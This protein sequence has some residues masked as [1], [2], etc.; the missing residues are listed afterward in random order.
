MARDAAAALCTGA[1]NRYPRFGSVSMKRG[2]SAVSPRAS[3]RRF[4]ALFSPRSKSTKVSAGHTCRCSSSRVTTSPA[5]SSRRI[6][7][8]N[9]WAAS[10]TRTPPFR[11]SPERRSIPKTPKEVMQSESVA[12]L[13]AADSYRPRS[14]ASPSAASHIEL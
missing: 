1:M 12:M 13:V 14:R 2:L 8:W 10:L 6:N 3:R 9:G 5:R 7:T 11:S 4:T